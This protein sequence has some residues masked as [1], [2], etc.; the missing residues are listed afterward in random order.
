MQIGACFCD[1]IKELCVE[2][3]LAVETFARMYLFYR[4]TSLAEARMAKTE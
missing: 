4:L 2:K 1:V 3:R